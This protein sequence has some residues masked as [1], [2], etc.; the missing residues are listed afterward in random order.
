MSAAGADGRASRTR[1]TPAAAYSARIS[2]FGRAPKTVTGSG[3]RP[4]SAAAFWRASIC[5]AVS[6]R[7]AMGIQPSP[8]SAARSI[9]FG[10]LP[11]RITGGWGAAPAWATARRGRSRR[12]RR[13]TR[14]PRWSR[15]P[16]WPA[17]VPGAG[18]S[19]WRR[20]VPW[21]SISSR[22]Q[23]PP[24]PNR[25][26][27]PE[28]RSTVATSLAVTIGSRSTTRQMPVPSRSRS[29]QAATAPRT[30]K[31]SGVSAELLGDVA[32]AGVGG[33]AADGDVGVLGHEQR[34]EAPLLE[35]PAEGPHV[36][37]V[38]VGKVLIPS[39]TTPPS[40]SPCASCIQDTVR[41]G[42]CPGRSSKW[43]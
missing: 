43:R 5:S 34:L 3:P 26:R 42:S 38:S 8:H 1:S 10:P 12:T 37:A 18:R 40:G 33:E 17:P 28:R 9:D 16:S 36:D 23:P 13:G 4:R 27:P 24:T 29:V 2:G 22:F 20:S 21:F 35:R 39:R 25:N 6:P 7:P 31:G 32:A 41:C 19:G 30:T 14:P 11:A 15:W